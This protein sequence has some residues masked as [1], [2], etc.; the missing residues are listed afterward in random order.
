MLQAVED[1][2]GL[3]EK[4]RATKV[5]KLDESMRVACPPHFWGCRVQPAA[6]NFIPLDKSPSSSAPLQVAGAS[7][8]P[9]GKAC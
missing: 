5:L 4:V 2:R 1:T 7:S 8:S 9:F 3:R 6:P